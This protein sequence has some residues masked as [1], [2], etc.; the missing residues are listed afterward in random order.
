MRKHWG[1][2]PVFAYESMLNAR[3]WQV[4]AGR[5]VFVLLLL[6][7][8]AIVWVARIRLG[9]GRSLTWTTY[10]QMA[11]L[12][13]WFFYVMAGIQVSL[14]ILATPASTAGSICIDRARGT[15]A[16]MMVTDLSDAEIV[17]GKFGAGW[18][19]SWD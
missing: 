6:F 3:R 12:G 8:L 16:H 14:V 13:E 19:R 4:Y 15:L 9:F 2:G 11:K 10:E 7:G 17:L 18:H 5:S 1:T